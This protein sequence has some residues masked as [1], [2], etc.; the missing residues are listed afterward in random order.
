MPGWLVLLAAEMGTCFQAAA[1]RLSMQSRAACG[2][3]NFG[4]FG[5]L[6][7]ACLSR[8]C[9]CCHPCLP[10]CLLVGCRASGQTLDKEAAAAMAELP[11]EQQ[12]TIAAGFNE[13]TGLVTWVVGQ[14]SRAAATA[15]TL[16]V[17]CWC[18]LGDAGVYAWHGSLC[19]V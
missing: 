18:G 13:F 6:L 8:H 1:G 15:V 12:Q 19:W 16:N 10:A 11:P 14:G 17:S 7:Q 4:A 9:H 3:N 5:A 2:G